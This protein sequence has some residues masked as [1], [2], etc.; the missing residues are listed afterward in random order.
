MALVYLVQH[1]QLGSLHAL[2]VLHV[3]SAEIRERLLREGRVQSRLRHP[4]I[5]AVTDVVQVD[6]APGLVM[7]YIDGPSLREV[8]DQHSLDPAQCDAV[9]RGILAGMEA[10]HAAGVIHRDLKPGRSCCRRQAPW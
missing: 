5:V 3:P 8:L 1:I 9:F 7:E 4:N 6:G 2:K 10:A